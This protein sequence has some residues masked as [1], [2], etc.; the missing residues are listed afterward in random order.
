M[1]KT[2]RGHVVVLQ[3]LHRPRRILPVR[4]AQLECLAARDSSGP[5]SRA[6]RAAPRTPRIA[7]ADASTPAG[8]CAIT[9]GAMIP[10]KMTLRCAISDIAAKTANSSTSETP[11]APPRPQQHDR[12]ADQQAAVPARRPERRRMPFLQ[13]ALQR[14]VLVGEQSGDHVEVRRIEAARQNRQQAGRPQRLLVL[15]RTVRAGAGTAP[16]RSIRPAA[17]SP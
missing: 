4:G 3:E 17:P 1:L 6:A 8:S 5:R 16:R 7:A 13:R 14:A 9:I 12:S 10:T 2:R 15:R 11:H